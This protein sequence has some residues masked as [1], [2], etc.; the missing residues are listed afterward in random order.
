MLQAFQVFGCINIPKEYRY[1]FLSF[2]QST[3]QLQIPWSDTKLAL[4]AI[5]D[6]HQTHYNHLVVFQLLHQVVVRRLTGSLR[7]LKVVYL[8]VA[9]EVAAE[10]LARAANT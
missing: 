5:G 3:D 10:I 7:N 6:A 1:H 4:G 9:V 8:G 2:F